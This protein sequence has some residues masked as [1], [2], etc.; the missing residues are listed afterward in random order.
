MYR[1]VLDAPFSLLMV[2]DRGF[3]TVEAAQAVLGTTYK[4]YP[5]MEVL[6]DEEITERV[7]DLSMRKVSFPITD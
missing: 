7:T 4:D 6:T 2:G 3:D 5:A 1:L